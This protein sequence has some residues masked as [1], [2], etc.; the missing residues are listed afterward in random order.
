[1]ST[2]AIPIQKPR[3]PSAAEI[4]RS[5][6]DRL[7]GL[8]TYN[9]SDRWVQL[10]IFG[11]THLWACPDLG[12]AIEAHPVQ[13]DPQTGTRLPV[14][15]D[16]RTIIRGRYLTQK[17]SSGKVIDG[18]DASSMV[19]TIIAPERYGQ[20]GFTWLPCA[21]ADEDNAL[22]ALSRQVWLDYRHKQD[23]DIVS[24]RAEFKANWTKGPHHKGDPCPPPTAVES[25]AMDRL[26][27][28]KRTA[29][30]KFECPVV[31]CPGYASND[32]DKFSDHMQ[33]AHRQGKLD[34]AKFEIAEVVGR[35]VPGSVTASGSV[36]VPVPETEPDMPGGIAEAAGV[37]REGMAPTQKPDPDEDEEDG[38]DKPRRRPRR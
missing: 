21:S 32:W 13:V 2:T 20:M 5:L 6:R 3:L 7:P 30:W 12:G 23:E 34:R 26:Q 36:P 18:Q 37:L 35:P 28:K 15:C 1:M 25:A 19:K 24:K 9:P 29:E 4:D 11:L 17:D 14:V 38:D 31:E 10:E 16:G 33:L 8:T 22:I 27:Q